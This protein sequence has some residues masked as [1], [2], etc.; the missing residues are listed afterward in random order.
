VSEAGAWRPTVTIAVPVLNEA[1]HIDACLDAIA[2]QTYDRIVQVLVVDGGSADGTQSLVAQRANVTLLHN[3]RRIQAAALNIALDAA[4]GEVFVRVDGHTMIAPDYVERC[5]DALL[6]TQASVV[7]G[8]MQPIALSWLQS[9]VAAAMTS[10]WGAGPARFHSP[11]GKSGWVDTVYLGAFW[12][13]D[14]R[15]VGGYDEGVGVNEDAEL[16][17]RMRGRR[18]VWFD[19]AIRSWYV[20]RDSL[21]AL[22]RQF[23]RYGCSRALTV[24]KHLGRL[25]PRQVAPPLLV[26]G[27]ISPWRRW[28]ASA[29]GA[30]VLL[31]T[32]GQMRRNPA[33][34][35]AFP[36]VLP[37]MHLSWGVGFLLGC[38]VLPKHASSQRVH[39]AKQRP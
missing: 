32:A 12:T 22:V 27:L 21:S 39:C 4:I 3:P 6:T 37:A 19:P 9:A 23:F 38:S 26:L 35:V 11:T 8:A 2:V 28:F 1:R 36:A 25:A 34:A 20:P 18:G 5:V 17:I 30:V 33:A 10:P 31:A 14:V 16:A 24:R 29:Y 7:G 13:A 15:A